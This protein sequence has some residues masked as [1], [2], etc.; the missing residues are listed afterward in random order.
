M[1]NTTDTINNCLFFI[2][3]LCTCLQSSFSC[4][5][6]GLDFAFSPI[7]YFIS[8]L[9]KGKLSLS[10]TFCNPSMWLT[11]WFSMPLEVSV[12]YL[13]RRSTCM[14]LHVHVWAY[15]GTIKISLLIHHIPIISTQISRW[16]TFYIHIQLLQKTCQASILKTRL[17]PLNNITF[18][19]ITHPIEISKAK[20]TKP[21]YKS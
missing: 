4:I 15:V 8:S 20:L 13:E 1:Y 21:G 5:W 19:I 10:V 18:T 7:F 14:S 3:K 12:S 17:V 11:K 9:L 2:T 16:Q 6:F